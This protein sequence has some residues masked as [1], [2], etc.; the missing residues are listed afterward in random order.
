MASHRVATTAPI[1]MLMAA[2]HEIW[3]L[4]PA[5]ITFRNNGW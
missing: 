1:E 2:L 4:S 3:L 5:G